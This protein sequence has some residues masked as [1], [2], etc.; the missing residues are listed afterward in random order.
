MRASR[1]AF[2]IVIAVGVVALLA[3][4]GARSNSGAGKEIVESDETAEQSA[5]RGR[6]DVE[7]PPTVTAPTSA[8]IHELRTAH[9]R[10]QVFVP[11]KLAHPAPLLLMFHGAGGSSEN[12]LGLVKEAAEQQGVIVVAP[13]SRDVTWDVIV[14]SFGPDVMTVSE[15]VRAA[16]HAFPIDH[17]KVAVAGFSDGASYALTMGM[18]NGDRFGQVIA[19]SPGFTAARDTE[20]APKIFISHGV[21]DSVLPIDVTSRR[22][23]DRLE[24]RYDITYREFEG[25]HTVPANMVDAAFHE[26]LG[27][28]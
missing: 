8:G 24:S 19:F 2:V 14:G 26:W 22:I 25:G 4:A 20:G 10:A 23:V 6:I 7:R 9:G 21:H 17:S 15:S 13:K 27:R 12:G 28:A 11:A 1:I 18:I 5:A 3:L 16:T